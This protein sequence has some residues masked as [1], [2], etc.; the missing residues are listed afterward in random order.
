M[1]EIAELKER[2]KLL[3]EQRQALQDAN[4][5]LKKNAF[6]ALVSGGAEEA[7]CRLLQQ[8]QRAGVLKN[9]FMNTSGHDILTSLNS[10]IG[11]LDV[12]FDLIDS[13]EQLDYVDMA[14]TESVRL[15]ENINR[16]LDVSRIE[17]GNL[18]IHNENFDLKETLDSDLYALS[19]D[20]H[21]REIEFSCDIDEGVPAYL[22]GDGKRLAQIVSGLVGDRVR[23]TRDEGAVAMNV[24]VDGYD[25]DNRQLIR[26][27]VTDTGTPISGV[28]LFELQE[29]MAASDT[30]HGSRPLAAGDASLGLL[31]SIQLVKLLGGS[32]GVESVNTGSMFWFS[33]SFDE[34]VEISEVVEEE[35]AAKKPFS[36]L[37]EKKILLAEDDAVNRILI[38]K[39]LE[40]QGASVVTAHDGLQAY[41]CIRQEKFDLAL[42]DIQMPV[43]DGFEATKKIRAFEK[44]TGARTKI[45]ALTAIADREKCLQAG[46]DDYLAKPVQKQLFFDMLTDHLTRSA[47][48]V[49][50]DSESVQTLVRCLVESGWRVSTAETGRQALYEA[51]LNHFDAF[52]L[53]TAL[54]NFK[55]QPVV[56]ILHKLDTYAGSRSVLIGLCSQEAD[57]SETMK[58]VLDT[59]MERPVNMEK[60]SHILSTYFD[61]SSSQ[62]TQ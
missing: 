43:L 5:L 54:P 59:V 9:Q 14:A 47:L 23:Y 42:M 21:D 7:C 36:I 29:F 4:D 41:N 60:I 32:I 12:L 49:D 10:I 25:A 33:L 61:V 44:G 6:V 27:L 50:D 53:D 16:I 35:S 1:S 30:P 39:M 17:S 2:I 45:I 40:Q 18:E 3:D 15:L 24:S 58:N 34:A 57:V 11:A 56:E 31:C 52:F 22:R 26:F 28:Q 13:E 48:V 62:R 8:V 38:T 19:L 37:R 46:M 55:D 20:A 51:S